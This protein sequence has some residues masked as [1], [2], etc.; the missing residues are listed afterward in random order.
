MIV[1]ILINPFIKLQQE[2][3]KLYIDNAQLGDTGEYICRCRT[4]SNGEINAT[5]ELNIERK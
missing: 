2:G 4:P 1:E 5:Y 3:N